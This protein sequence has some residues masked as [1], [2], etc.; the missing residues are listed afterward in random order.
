[1]QVSD[2]LVLQRTG[3]ENNQQSR[4]RWLTAFL[5]EYQGTII[6]TRNSNI[7]AARPALSAFTGNLAKKAAR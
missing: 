2:L 6:Q 3:A 1:M 4:K 7:K 5:Q